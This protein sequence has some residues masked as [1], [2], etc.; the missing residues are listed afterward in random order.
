MNYDQFLK[1]AKI[2]IR[3][4]SFTKHL[5]VWLL[6]ALLIYAITG[7]SIIS[8]AVMLR[9]LVNAFSV[10]L[11]FYG[12]GY[13]S[14]NFF[15]KKKYL[16]WGIGFLGL[17][18][19]VSVGR[20]YFE[21]KNIGRPIIE[22]ISKEDL[23]YSNLWKVSIFFFFIS[24]IPFFLGSFYYLQRKKAELEK[25]LIKMELKQ[26][27]AE[28][29]MLKNQLSPHFLFNTLNN[30]Y[31]STLLNKKQAPEMIL[32]LSE[33]FRYVIYTIRDKKVSLQTEVGQIK[34][35]LSL[36][37]LRFPEQVNVSFHVEGNL[38]HQ[39]PPMILLPIV[40]NAVKHCNINGENQKAFLMV[41]LLSGLNNLMFTVSNSYDQNTNPSLDSGV[42]QLNIQNRLLLEFPTNH[43]LF[44]HKYENSYEVNLEIKHLYE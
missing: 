23:I 33:L 43:H 8:N 30:I 26:V 15:D 38:N 10:M 12:G 24:L 31:S 21:F 3:A 28:L 4:W 9:S 25:H 39:I 42:G 11:T 14:V 36:Y 6:F 1:E 5:F 27:E 7:M 13:L 17:T 32:K 35:Y 34:N 2:P 40:E 41:S 20:A 16:I 22:L 18:S 29:G 44:F 19:T 37:Q